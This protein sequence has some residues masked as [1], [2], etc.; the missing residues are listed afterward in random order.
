[1]GPSWAAHVTWSALNLNILKPNPAHKSSRF[2]AVYYHKSI[3]FIVATSSLLEIPKNEQ[4]TDHLCLKADSGGKNCSKANGPLSP[5]SSPATPDRNSVNRRTSFELGNSEICVIL[6][7]TFVI[8][9]FYLLW[10][11]QHEQIK[12]SGKTSRRCSISL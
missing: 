9:H 3:S 5:D 10:S 11:L 8:I 4:R 7:H 1:M 6:W 12:I 2:A